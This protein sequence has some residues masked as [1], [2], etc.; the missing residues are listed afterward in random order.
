MIT[1]SSSSKTI[2]FE[3]DKKSITTICESLEFQACDPM[4]IGQNDSDY[5]AEASYATNLTA[6]ISA[7][8]Q[9]NKFSMY[10]VFLSLYYSGYGG[11]EEGRLYLKP[12]EGDVKYYVDWIVSLFS[13]RFIADMSC[14]IFLELCLPDDHPDVPPTLQLTASSN[15]IVAVSGLHK[16]SVGRSSQ[17]GKWTKKLCESLMKSKKLPLTDVLDSIGAELPELETHYI[18]SARPIYIDKGLFAFLFHILSSLCAFS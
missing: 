10:T 9:F 18:S 15:M 12:G 11:V 3:N 5:E 14:L 1:A 16:A 2:D 8:S 4:T 7:I 13:Q 6:A 17:G